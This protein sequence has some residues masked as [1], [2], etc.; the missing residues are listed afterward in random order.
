MCLCRHTVTRRWWWWWC[1]IARDFNAQIE[2]NSIQ[3]LGEREN[4]GGALT[5]TNLH[6]ITN[7]WLN[8]TRMV[9]INCLWPKRRRRRR[10]GWCIP[11]TQRTHKHY[12]L[13]SLIMLKHTEALKI[14]M[15]ICVYIW[16]V[17]ESVPARTCVMEVT[18][19]ASIRQ[20][21]NITL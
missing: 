12:H 8:R 20:A 11:Y 16:F 2:T 5:N 17:I 4:Q 18:H 6:N 15:R 9:H 14:N 1:M 7:N 13:I 10:P 21:R 3:S 19:S